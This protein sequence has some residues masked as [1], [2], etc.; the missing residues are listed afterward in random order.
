MRDEEAFQH[1]ACSLSVLRQLEALASVAV[2]VGD[3]L[4]DGQ[5]VFEC[6]TD[7][8]QCAL[9]PRLIGFD[10]DIGRQ[11]DDRQAR[12]GGMVVRTTSA[13]ADEATIGL[14]TC[15]Q[16]RCSR[17]CVVEIALFAGGVVQLHQRHQRGVVIND[18]FLA[19]GAV[20]RVEL[21]QVVI[22]ALRIGEITRPIEFT[23]TSGLFGQH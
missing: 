13:I 21:A 12:F 19:I 6:R 22:G 18:V 16:T 5:F 8:A 3:G 10:I 7:G 1:L 23:M 9:T 15:H 11:A 20:L 4:G 17:A 14:L 2:R